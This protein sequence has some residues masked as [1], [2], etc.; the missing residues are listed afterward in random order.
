MPNA[1]ATP[2]VDIS[3]VQNIDF[4]HHSQ[5]LGVEGSILIYDLKSDRV[6][7]YN[8]QHNATAFLPASTFKILNSLISLETGVISD[9]IA[10]I[11]L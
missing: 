3:V 5:E 7:Q 10:V 6:F 9:E 1:V 2:A 11:S 8:L 4:K